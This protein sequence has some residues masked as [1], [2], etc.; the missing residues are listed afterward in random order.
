M[1]CVQT[2]LKGGGPDV[3]HSTTEQYA[4]SKLSISVVGHKEKSITNKK[5]WTKYLERKA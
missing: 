2:R 4:P 1:F 5:I 3:L